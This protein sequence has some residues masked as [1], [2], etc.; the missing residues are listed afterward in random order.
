MDRRCTTCTKLT[1][2]PDTHEAEC[3]ALETLDGKVGD[4]W[5]WDNSPAWITACLDYTIKHGKGGSR[6]KAR[7]KRKNQVRERAI[8]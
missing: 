1:R 2:N 4:C 7:R 5:A 8:S 6:K 3:L